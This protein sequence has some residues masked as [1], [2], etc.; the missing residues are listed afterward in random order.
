[1]SQSKLEM[2]VDILQTLAQMGPSTLS[3][4]ECKARVDVVILKVVFDFLVE[5]NFVKEQTIKVKPFF[6]VTQRGMK[7]LKYFRGTRSRNTCVKET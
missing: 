3:G 4:I 7:V 2:Y 5:Q 6:E 1:M